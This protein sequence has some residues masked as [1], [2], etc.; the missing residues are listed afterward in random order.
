MI[1]VITLMARNE[2]PLSAPP[3]WVAELF[4]ALSHI[5]KLKLRPRNLSIVSLT[6]LDVE[7]QTYVTLVLGNS[8]NGAIRASRQWSNFRSNGE[9]LVLDSKGNSLVCLGADRV[10]PPVPSGLALRRPRFWL[11]LPP[12]GATPKRRRDSVSEDSDTITDPPVS[13]RP[14]TLNPS[15]R[16]DILCRFGGICDPG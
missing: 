12:A 9:K 6:N 7:C 16:A 2:F 14:A 3:R 5:V 13:Q 15:A 11:G 1:E 10:S 4:W 8:G